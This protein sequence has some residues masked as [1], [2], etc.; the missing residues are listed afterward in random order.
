MFRFRFLLAAVILTGA[1]NASAATYYVDQTS[2]SDSNAGTASAPWKNCP[3]MSSYTGSRSLS[4]GDVVYFDRGD[5]WVLTGAQGLYLTGGVTYLGDSWGSGTRAT[6]RAGGNLDAGVVRFRDHASAPTVFRG[7]DV[8]A[9]HTISTGIDVNHRYYTLM[10]GAT[11]RIQNVVVHNVYSDLT[12][13]QY[14]YGIIISNF[15]GTSGYTEN[16]EVLDSVVH[17]T[18]RDAIC[19][20]PGDT[21]PDNRIRNILVRGNE[22]Y[23]TGQ[24]PNYCCGSGI[25]IKGFVQDATIEDNYIHNVKGASIFMNANENSH[26]AGVG[27]VNIHIRHNIITNSTANGAI[28]IYD[29]PS[30]GDAKDVKVYGNIVYNSTVNGGLLIGSDLKNT[31]NLAVYNN[32]FYNAPVIINSNSAT[33]NTFEFKNNIVYYSG[34]TPLTDAQGQITAHANNIYFRGGSGA[35]VSSRG[36]SYSASNLSS[37]ESSASAADPLFTNAAS[38]PNGFSGVFG[39]NLAPNTDG[40]RLQG[41]SPAVDRGAALASAYAGSIN[42]VVRPSGAGWDIGAYELSSSSSTA[43]HPPTN[44]RITGNELP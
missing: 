42:S 35:L 20:Y 43:P 28:R 44:V 7:F 32:T 21:S 24:D 18:S 11:K 4:P 40:L 38:L 6:L 1:A 3:G 23:N 10:N 9:N 30:G 14:K 8:D 26:Y 27:L 5:T 12:Q 33:V 17:D 19:L 2:G 13:G 15:G 41:G 25:L 22:A 16:V 34:G 31:L 37:Y 39:N 36:S 29:G